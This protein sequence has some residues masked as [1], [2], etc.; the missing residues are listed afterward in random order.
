MFVTNQ[1]YNRESIEKEVQ[2]TKI[3]YSILPDKRE[4]DRLELETEMLFEKT[5][6]I[7]LA[8][9]DEKIGR[10]CVQSFVS[11]MS[12]VTSLEELDYFDGFTLP[13]N[14]MSDTTNCW[15]APIWAKA[16]DIVF[17]MHS[18]TAKSTL[19]GLRTQLIQNR[20][21]IRP[22]KYERLM[23]HIDHALDIHSRLGGKI[24]A[25]GRICGGVEYIDPEDYVDSILHWKSRHY[26]NIDNI[27][28]LENPI[29]ISE[30]RNYI[31]IS[32]GSS[33][34]PLFDDEYDRLKEDIS[35]FN[36]IPEYVKES[37]ARPIP[38]RKINNDNWIEVSNAYRRCFILEKQFRK[39]YVDYL[40]REL[41]DKKRFYTECR[42]QKPSMN[43][44][45]MDYAMLFNGKYL[46]VETKLSVSAE[47]NIIGQVRKYVYNSKV[48]LDNEGKTVSGEQFHNGKV[49]IIDTEKMYIYDDKQKD[50]KEI[51]DLDCIESKEDLKTAKNAIMAALFSDE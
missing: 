12:T 19:T 38:L 30:F 22:G 10:N 34:T 20:N 16:G 27:Y 9:P 1:K 49:L 26:S 39:F 45:F 6:Q 11:N 32:R 15:T 48:F 18:K 7:A 36:D 28:I 8:D 44:S 47:P 41:G 21:K 13:E 35:K 33:I 4:I 14:I 43:D 50:V 24:F 46:P 40:V 37:V 17:F 25:I 2:Y 51:L 3:H 42:C 29:D 23:A 31:Y 5:Q